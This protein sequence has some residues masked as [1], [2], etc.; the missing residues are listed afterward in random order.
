[1]RWRESC[2]GEQECA[3]RTGIRRGLCLGVVPVEEEDV[4]VRDQL[5]VYEIGGV[6]NSEGVMTRKEVRYALP[7]FP[8]SRGG[9]RPR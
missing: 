2:K 7:Q 5:R 6:V 8:A 4:G 3:R 1:M 9:Q